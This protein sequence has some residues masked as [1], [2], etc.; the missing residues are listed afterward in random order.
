[1]F[2][3]KPDKRLVVCICFT[4]I[5][6]TTFFSCGFFEKWNSKDTACSFSCTKVEDTFVRMEPDSL[7][8]VIIR[9]NMG[10]C[11]ISILGGA[12]LALPTIVCVVS[13]GKALGWQVAT[14]V[15]DYKHRNA[16]I[17]RLMPHG[18]EIFAFWL[19]G[20]MGFYILFFLVD[21][22]RNKII[23]VQKQ[24]NIMFVGILFSVTLVLFA[25]LIEA[26]VSSR[27]FL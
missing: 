26:Y 6:W 4:A 19:S 11:A 24:L 16:R 22:A 8:S 7:Y 27:L 3:E 17:L 2:I 15:R 5:L 13:N 12:L 10:V 25:A 18:F 20:G 21:L 14:I 23:N 1:M 9:N